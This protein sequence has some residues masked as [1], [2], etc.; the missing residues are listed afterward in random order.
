MKRRIPI[1]YR[2]ALTESVTNLDLVVTPKASVYDYTEEEMGLID[3]Q[4][5][6]VHVFDELKFP[7]VDQE[8]L[9]YGL[10]LADEAYK[11]LDTQVPLTLRQFKDYIHRHGTLT[12]EEFRDFKITADGLAYA[13]QDNLMPAYFDAYNITS[14]EYFDVIMLS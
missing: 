3:G 12:R 2:R 7:D 14:D 9:G 6:G 8:M 5:T 13:W 10:D 1:G 4:I 11:W